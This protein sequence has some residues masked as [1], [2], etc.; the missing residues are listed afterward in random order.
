MSESTRQRG[1]EGQTFLVGPTLYLRGIELED[2][3][4]GAAWYP[5]S[6]PLPSEVLEE[7]LNKEVPEGMRKTEYR[8]VACRR[9]DDRPVGSVWYGIHGWR[10]AETMVHAD[11]ALGAEARAAIKA[12]IVGL[13]VPYLVMERD[14][15][16]VWFDAEADESTVEGT[17]AEI[18]MRKAFR[19]R[20]ALLCDGVR[21]DLICY[22]ALHPAW[23]ARLGLP[24]E[25][26]EGPVER[27]VRLPAPRVFPSLGGDPPTG[28]I[29]VGERVYLRA[30]EIDDAEE[31][32][33]WSRREPETFFDNGRP[34]RSPIAFADFH[35]K[36]AEDDP[37][38]RVRFAICLRE[39]DEVIG[40]NG[41]DDLD[42]IGRT[43]ET[44]T[45]IVD[46]AYR[47]G[48]YGTE[49][50]HLLLA[51][52][53]ERLGLHMVKSYAWEF[54]TRSAAALRKQGYREAG[55]VAWVGLK[56]GDFAG[57]RVFDLLASEWQAARR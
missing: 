16:V 40:S 38:G 13:V 42:W 18:G 52:A 56:D 29:M 51:Y 23:I 39:N 35:R 1:S 47:G 24:P 55:Y 10:S 31:M 28:A 20:E 4:T 30:I 17:A 32:A 50:K 36:L 57:D 21:R 3:K 14:L 22:E 43:A 26:V 19:L 12:E 2:A 45:E 49:A 11:P 8:L 15:M 34:V 46:P 5:S 48:G 25:G 27:E 37:P 54:N 41:L 6:F 44:E 7:R 53:F 33:R 9:R